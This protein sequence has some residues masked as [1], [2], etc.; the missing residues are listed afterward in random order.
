MS[1]KKLLWILVLVIA[2]V[3]VVAIVIVMNN[4]SQSQK[5]NADNNS[6]NLTSVNRTA[7]DNTVNEE[8]KK[9]VEYTK[10]ELADGTLYTSTGKKEKADIVIGTNY[11]DTTIVD[12]YY[13]PDNYLDKLI[14][15]EGFYITNNDGTPYTF[16]ARY[17]SNALCPACPA[18]Y[19]A[20]E[21][22]L[23]GKIDEKFVDEDTWMKVVGILDVGNDETSGYEDYYFLKVVN[24][25]IMN[26][27]GQMTVTN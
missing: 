1:K 25:E 16:V 13:N 17:S 4:A 27:K 12:I 6:V 9:E 22:Q 23:Q 2:I 3:A 21:Y 15:I 11:F 24:L 19:S 18:G 26:E 8:E 5:D 20:L 7:S 10:L 14:E